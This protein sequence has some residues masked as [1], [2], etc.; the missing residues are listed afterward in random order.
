[1]LPGIDDVW[2]TS[3]YILKFSDYRRSCTGDLLVILVVVPRLPLLNVFFFTV[4]VYSF[5]VVVLVLVLVILSVSLLVF[6]FLFIFVF[7]A[8]GR[9]L[10]SRHLFLPRCAS[11]RCMLVCSSLFFAPTAGLLLW[12]RS[13]LSVSPSFSHLQGFVPM[14]WASFFHVPWL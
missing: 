1:M 8:N 4:F 9:F 6:V 7:C 3:F 11:N 10:L 14:L 5:V 12:A 13:C 2:E